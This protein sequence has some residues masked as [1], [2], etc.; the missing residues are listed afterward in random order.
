MLPFKMNN[1]GV[2][3]ILQSSSNIEVTPSDCLVSYPGHSFG[4]VLPSA[5]MQSVDSAV[6]WNKF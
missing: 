3:H 1:E 4:G 5:K 6:D 2:F